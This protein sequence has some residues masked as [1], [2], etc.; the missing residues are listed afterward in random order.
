M[1]EKFAI[2]HDTEKH[3]Q[4]LIT[5]EYDLEDKFYK[6]TYQFELEGVMPVFSLNIK[7]RKKA[8]K[9]FKE[10]ENKETAISEIDKIIIAIQRVTG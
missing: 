6:I 1:K 4:I 3:G 9:V 2:L 7:S 10:L 5:K 8:N